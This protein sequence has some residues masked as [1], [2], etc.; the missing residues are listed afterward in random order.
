MVPGHGQATKTIM[1]KLR[2]GQ[3]VAQRVYVKKNP[4]RGAYFM[5]INAQNGRKRAKFLPER[6]NYETFTEGWQKASW[7]NRAAPPEATVLEWINKLFSREQGFEALSSLD[8]VEDFYATR[9]E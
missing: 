7:E 8:A 9:R 1:P 2:D 6:F 4:R 5:T 3:K